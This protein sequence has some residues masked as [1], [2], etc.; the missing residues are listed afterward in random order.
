MAAKC[1]LCNT[2]LGFWTE[3]PLNALNYRLRATHLTEIIDYVNDRITELAAFALANGVGITPMVPISATTRNEITSGIQHL[4]FRKP[5]IDEIRESIRDVLLTFEELFV[6]LPVSG[7]SFVKEDYFTTTPSLEA[8]ATEQTTFIDPT[9]VVGRTRIRFMHIE[10]LRHLK[11]VYDFLFAKLNQEIP[12]ELFFEDFIAPVDTPET[13]ST[14]STGADNFFLGGRFLAD[15]GIWEIDPNE[16]DTFTHGQLLPPFETL[17]NASQ[18][19]VLGPLNVNPASSSAVGQLSWYVGELK[20]FGFAPTFFKLMSSIDVLP[21]AVDSAAWRLAVNEYARQMRVLPSSSFEFYSEF[22]GN[23]GGTG[24][25]DP[26]AR[27]ELWFKPY[28]PVGHE[29]NDT[30]NFTFRL[31]HWI[32]TPRFPN[33]GNVEVTPAFFNG[34]VSMQLFDIM[35]GVF[36]QSLLDFYDGTISTDGVFLN[37]ILILGTNY[38]AQPT[39]RWAIDKVTMRFNKFVEDFNAGLLETASDTKA[40]VFDTYTG[41]QNVWAS[42]VKGSVGEEATIDI[43]SPASLG[44]AVFDCESF[45][46]T[47]EGNPVRRQGEA[48]LTYNPGTA[49]NPNPTL[50]GSSKLLVKFGSVVPSGFVRLAVILNI[51]DGVTPKTLIFPLTPD[52]I[53]VGA[54]P[55]TFISSVLTSEVEF[56]ISSIGTAIDGYNVTQV[57]LAALGGEAAEFTVSPFVLIDAGTAGSISGVVDKLVISE[58]ELTLT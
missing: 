26:F 13:S 6:A 53:G 36:G 43:N 44:N 51:S 32:N 35:E 22:E 55:N 45:L 42:T 50:T 7:F 41:Q 25:F 15:E 47:V 37:R 28:L 19:M 38:P 21:E 57:Q 27:I 23:P 34:N 49:D 14:G 58:A 9:L 5:W 2:D 16:F 52:S 39:L 12:D 1:P 8:I 56:P 30:A 18:G 54:E 4:Q 48:L 40:Q 24:A 10:D 3:D 33:A 29:F 11:P 17:L 46:E 31:I 20:T